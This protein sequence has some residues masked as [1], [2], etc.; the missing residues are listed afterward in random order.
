M[1][2]IPFDVNDVKLRREFLESGMMQLLS[3]LGAGVRPLWGGMTAQHMVEH[4]LWTFEFSTGDTNV[5]RDV[6][7]PVAERMR[8]FLH[9][10]RPTPHDFKNPLLGDTPPPLIFKNLEEARTALQKAVFRF[11]DLNGKNPEAIFDHPL[12]GPLGGEEWERALFK[13]CYHHLEQFGLIEGEK[14][15]RA[16]LV[17]G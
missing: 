8:R 1:I 2:A 15:Q 3:S 5:H 9:D 14:S 17:K 4:L 16:Q 13:H 7:A 6:P 12:F 11:F 10:D